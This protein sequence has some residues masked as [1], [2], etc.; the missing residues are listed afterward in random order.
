[1]SDELDMLIKL[2]KNIVSQNNIIIRQNEDIINLLKKIADNSDDKG[3]GDDY[4]VMGEND[5]RAEITTDVFK[6][7]LDAGEVL[8]VTYSV[9]E[10]LCVYKLSAKKSSELKVV[11]A[12]IEDEV[13]NYLKDFGSTNYEITLDNLTGNGTTSQF[14]IPLLVALE[15]LN[16][17]I[18]IESSI[19]ILGNENDNNSF[20]FIENLPEV[21][22]ISIENGAEKVYLPINSAISVAQAPP[23]I[24][25]YL[26][27]YK[28][29]SDAIEKL[30]K[31]IE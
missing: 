9:N 11:P 26:V 6:K 24:L 13:G 31:K 19:A 23:M 1:M 27:F 2:N 29:G 16:Q 4:V 8:T 3:N 25:E 21:L 12:E 7:P 10:E 17:N 28:S 18:P 5:E 20:D 22:R 30:F 14:S 15:S